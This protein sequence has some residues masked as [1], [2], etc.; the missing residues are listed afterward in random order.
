MLLLLA[1]AA[2]PAEAAPIRCFTPDYLALRD[3]AGAAKMFRPTAVGF[4]DSAIYPIRI[5]YSDAADLA[6]ATDSWLP[7]AE[8]AWAV[9]VEQMGWPAPPADDGAGGS[10]AYDYYFTEKGTS[11]GAYTFGF[12]P[13]V[14]PDDNWYSNATFIAVDRR[15]DDVEV[16][17]FIAHE[18]VHALQWTVDGREKT[19][20]AWESTAEAITDMVHDDTDY[21]YE[22]YSFQMLPFMSLV[23]DSYNPLIYPYGYTGY[24]YEY[25]GMM[26]TT[27]IEE[28]YGTKD[29]KLLV[30]LWD[31][32]A[33]PGTKDEP[34]FLDAIAL[35]DPSV[36]TVADVYTDFAVWRMFAASDD[37][38]AHYE[39]G[40]A[41]PDYAIPYAE[42]SITLDELDGFTATPVAAPYDLG[43]SYYRVDLGVGSD[44]TL[45]VDVAGEPGVE[46]GIAWAV[47]PTAGGAATTGSTWVADGAPLAVDIDLTG[48]D[49]LEIG[50]V[51]NGP[52]GFDPDDGAVRRA[53]TLTLTLAPLDEPADTDEPP[54][55][56]TDVP[57]TDVPVADPEPEPPASDD[58]EK[59]GCGCA[60]GGPL[61]VSWAALALAVVA[62]RRRR[63]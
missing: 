36:P 22:L 45:H 62:G 39:E 28:K 5:H 23:H 3:D 46:W 43:T 19:V 1:L 49:R 59:G 16:D 50:V 11:M 26:F 31:D 37:D 55:D 52:A 47:W 17:G 14:I 25:G 27:Y 63:R 13:D 51:N 7:L 54:V 44:R 33:Q 56:D 15:I 24:Y 32:L 12:G 38:G 34:D 60:S 29:G 42:A 53:F 57:D 8:N 61:Q 41:F 21:G 35:V 4:V 20:F 2:P 30:K 6:R 58:D 40:A 18:F 9:E 10:D 48:G